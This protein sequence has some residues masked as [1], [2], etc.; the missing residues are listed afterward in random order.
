MKR[1]FSTVIGRCALILGFVFITALN[2]N[3]QIVVGKITPD[4]VWVPCGASAPVNLQFNATNGVSISNFCD[5]SQLIPYLRNGL[6]AWYPFCTADPQNDKSGTANHFNT[7]IPNSTFLSSSLYTNDISNTLKNDRF[8]NTNTTNAFGLNFYTV[9]STS[10]QF[11]LANKFNASI[12]SNKLTLSFWYQFQKNSL[13]NQNRGLFEMWDTVGNNVK[14]QIW[15]T[16]DTSAAGTGDTLFIRHAL[17]NNTVVLPYAQQKQLYSWVFVSVV[18][19]A[20]AGTASFYLNGINIKTES[21]TANAAAN[22]FG[23]NF[24]FGRISQSSAWTSL[25][26]MTADIDDIFIH[27]RKLSDFEVAALYRVYRYKWNNNSNDS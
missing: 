6:V 1:F 22:L 14:M 5:N 12:N 23:T 20:T 16:N 18:I 4:S 8:V 17:F 10:Y 24:Q 19:D 13:F 25:G 27:N 9:A 15:N 3:A 2:T 11:I 7:A 26:G 21:F